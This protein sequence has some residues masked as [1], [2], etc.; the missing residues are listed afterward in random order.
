MKLTKTRKI[1]QLNVNNYIA[2]DINDKQKLKGGS[3]ITT[4]FQPGYNKV[5]PLGTHVIAKAQ[6]EFYTKKTN[7]VKFLLEHAEVSDFCVTCTKGGTY[8]AMVQKNKDGE[9]EMGKVARVIGTMND[10][11]GVIKKAK[12]R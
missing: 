12:V 10:K 5:R 7:P 1:W 9:I 11:Y 4:I 3:F 2:V 8:H 6:I